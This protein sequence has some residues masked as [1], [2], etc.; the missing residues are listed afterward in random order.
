MH[1]LSQNKDMLIKDYVTLA[2]DSMPEHCIL[3]CVTR[4]DYY[5]EIGICLAEYE[6]KERCLE[7]IKDISI[8]IARG[9]KCYEMPSR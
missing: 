9:V 5:R 7:V 3:C 1:I 2:Y 8:A 4:E 6:T